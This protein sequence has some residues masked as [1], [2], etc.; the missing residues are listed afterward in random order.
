[1]ST[2]PL[3]A[4]AFGLVAAPGFAAEPSAVDKKIATLTAAIDKHLAADWAARTIKP[5]ADADDAEFCRRVYLDVIGRIPK[6]SEVRAFEA[7][8]ATDKRAK[9]VEVL[10]TKPSHATHFAS[11]A[12]SKWLPETLT[13]Q[14]TMFLGQQFEDWLRKRFAQN[15]KMDEVV[16]TVL[17]AEVFLGQRGQFQ[18]VQRGRGYDADQV[19]IQSFYQA[20]QSKPENLGSTVTRA[21]LGVKLECAQCHDHPFAPYTREQFWQ[22]AAFFGE[23]TPLPPNRPSFVG[24]VKPQA[25]NNTLAIAGTSRKVTAAF[26]DGTSPNWTDD[27]SPREELADWVTA[28]ENQYFARNLANRVWAQLFGV[29]I[30]DPVDEPGENNPP[31]HPE[32][33]EALAKGYADCGFD[34]RAMIRA[35][36]ASK[37]YNRTSRISHPSQG[38]PRRFARMNVKSLTGHQIYDSFATATGVRDNQPRN[39]AYY[40]QGNGAVTRFS[41]KTLFPDPPKPTET[42]TS[43][44]QALALMNG[45]LTADQTSLDK[46]EILAAV[47]DAPFL[48][49][50]KRLETLFF[51]ALTRKPTP[52]E[53]EKLASYVDRGGPS[54]DKK[55][56]LADVFWVL[57]NSPEFL[58]NH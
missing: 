52:E 41:I 45:R 34:Q 12:R 13:D 11:V 54:G 48:N 29:G 10:L 46:S 18:A 57:L 21:F 42:Q 5:A 24:P 40:D 1:M 33:L 35:I 38:D 22:L 9:L 19:A 15:V 25:D 4:L 32:L 51:T 28:P 58:F 26:K 17:T 49:T 36:V 20:A 50:E 16:R 30:L 3:L 31:S 2:R 6:V 27:K 56:A 14:Q 43:I 44:L 37:A 39:Q 8:P 47:I 23:F 53:L 55:K 7:D